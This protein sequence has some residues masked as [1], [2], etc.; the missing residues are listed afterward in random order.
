MRAYTHP[1]RVTELSI[2]VL[3]SLFIILL[4][5]CCVTNFP[6]MLIAENN[7]E[8]CY[9]LTQFLCIRN[10]GAAELGGSGLRS[11]MRLRSRHWLELQSA[12]GLTGAGGSAPKIAPHTVIGRRP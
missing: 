6:E 12:E 9:Y 11:L 7:N 4:I 10:L 8:H 5:Y 3:F 2:G 1:L